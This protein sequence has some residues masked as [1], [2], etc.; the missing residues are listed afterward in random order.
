MISGEG[1]APLKNNLLLLRAAGLLIT[2]LFIFTGITYWDQTSQAAAITDPRKFEDPD[3]S[4]AESDMKKL[5]MLGFSR[6]AITNMTKEEAAEFLKIDGKVVDQV[7]SY[8]RIVKDNGKVLSKKKYMSLLNSYAKSS[9]PRATSLEKVNMSLLHEGDRKFTVI[10]EH[11]FDYITGPIQPM[12]IEIQLGEEDTLL[13]QKAKQWVWTVSDFSPEKLH[14]GSEEIWA[15]GK[16]MKENEFTFWDSSSPA[17]YYSVPWV[18][19]S[20]LEDVVGLHFMTVIR[21]EV[22]DDYNFADVYMQGM[23]PYL[24]QHLQYEIKNGE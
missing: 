23:G 16:P 1:G 8:E 21:F 7:E 13:D 6:I 5:E 3:P 14:W 2:L 10:T 17:L 4:I 19:P 22:P 24:S 15:T 9:T 12:E 18:Q 11:H 20:F